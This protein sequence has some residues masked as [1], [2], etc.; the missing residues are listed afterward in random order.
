MF[1]EPT[2]SE[3]LVSVLFAVYAAGIH[4]STLCG[5]NLRDCATGPKREMPRPLFK[6]HKMFGLSSGSGVWLVR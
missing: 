6:Q 5:R 3:Q 4:V 1:L 2:S